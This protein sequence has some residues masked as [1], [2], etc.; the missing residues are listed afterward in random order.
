MQLYE[1]SD[2]RKRW[3]ALLL[4]LFCFIAVTGCSSL[5]MREKLDESINQYNDLLRRRMM[6]EASHFTVDSLRREFEARAKASEGSRI[7]DYRVV[8]VKFDKEKSEAE[9]RVEIDYYSLSTF[10][11]KTLTDTQKWAFLGEGG[12]KKWRLMSPLPEFK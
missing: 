3:N 4:I 6:G 10:R 8:D 11:M 2:R 5:N 7:A 1:L 9:A 12:S